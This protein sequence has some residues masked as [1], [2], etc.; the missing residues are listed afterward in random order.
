MDVFISI[1]CWRKAEVLVA[2]VDDDDIDLPATEE[3]LGGKDKTSFMMSSD[4]PCVLA[5]L[6]YVIGK[7]HRRSCRMV[8]RGAVR[9]VFPLNWSTLLESAAQLQLY[10]F[11]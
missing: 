2:V 8:D 1:R 3:L 11:M 6:S 10:K 4:I 7:L 9:S 5:I